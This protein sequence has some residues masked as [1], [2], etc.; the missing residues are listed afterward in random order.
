MYT[1]LMMMIRSLL[2]ENLPTAL[3]Q[4]SDEAHSM[5]PNLRFMDRT[6]LSQG[7]TDFEMTLDSSH[8]RQINKHKTPAAD[9]IFWSSKSTYFTQQI[10]IKKIT[11]AVRYWTAKALGL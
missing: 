2:T 9:K 5:Y 7:S 6:F 10:L 3:A 8:L 1:F 11:L 4:R